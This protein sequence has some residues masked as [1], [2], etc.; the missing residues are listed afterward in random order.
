MRIS[1]KVNI[2]V[3]SLPL[4]IT[5]RYQDCRQ[6][7]HCLPMSSSKS[8]WHST[9]Q[10]QSKSETRYYDLDGQRSFRVPVAVWKQ[11]NGPKFLFHLKGAANSFAVNMSV[12]CSVAIFL[13]IQFQDSLARKFQSPEK[14]GTA[15]SKQFDL[16]VRQF[17]L[18][19][20]KFC[21]SGNFWWRK[22]EEVRE[23]KSVCRLLQQ[24]ISLFTK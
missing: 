22:R 21:R 24:W 9:E 23:G 6:L 5:A 8:Y 16:I 19:F 17:D 1:L 15:F 20:P 3:S 18:I 12:L 4:L 14:P 11:E 7:G 2:L 13:S 10:R